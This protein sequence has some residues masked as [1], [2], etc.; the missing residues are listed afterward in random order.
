[1]EYIIVVELNIAISPN[2]VGIT[3]IGIEKPIGGG[4]GN[5]MKFTTVMITVLNIMGDAIM[6]SILNDKISFFVL[7]VSWTNFLLFIKTTPVYDPNIAIKL[8]IGPEINCPGKNTR[9]EIKLI[10]PDII[11]VVGP[12]KN[13]HMYKGISHIV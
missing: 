2:V 12:N 5:A 11:A 13:K 7:F 8:Y 6:N 1:M 10:I 9:S 3:S 4:I